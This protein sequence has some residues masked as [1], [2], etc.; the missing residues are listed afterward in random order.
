[1]KKIFDKQAESYFLAT[2]ALEG[3]WDI[4]KPIIF[5]G[6]W[7]LRYSRKSFWE[8]LEYQII[9]SPL[10]SNQEFYNAYCYVSNLYER[11]LPLLGEKL[12][13][14]HGTS[15]SNRYWRIVIGPW[16]FQYIHVLYDRY[17]SLRVALD[18]YSNFTTIGLSEDDYI[19]PSN[20][21]DFTNLVCDD[22]YNLQL[23]TRIL[24]VLGKDFPRKNL[25]VI[26]SPVL[27]PGKRKLRKLLGSFY[28][29]IFKVVQNNS[30]PIVIKQAYFSRFIEL[31]LFFKT[32]GKIW[33]D[34]NK[35]ELP[36]FPFNQQM[37]LKLSDLQLKD[38]EFEKLLIDMLFFDIPKSY[39]E[40]FLFISNEIDRYYPHKPIAIFSAEAWY[41]EEVFKQWAAACAEKGT[42]LFGIQHG[43]NYGSVACLPCEIHEVSITDV[44]YSWGWEKTD[45][46]SRVLP[47]PATRLMG[48]KVMGANNQKEGI[49]LATNCMP[50]YLYRFQNFKNYDNDEYFSWQQRFAAALSSENRSKMR[51]RLYIQDYGSDCIQRW[52]DYYPEVPLENWDIYFLE[53]LENCRLHVSDHL[54]STFIDALVANK[55]TI[56]FWNH[57]VFEVRPEAQPYYDELRYAG[58]L[59]NTPEAAATAVNFFYTDVETWWN[60]PNLQVIRK[61]F[62]NIFAKTSPDAVNEWAN[63]FKT[64][65]REMKIN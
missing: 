25:K 36:L 16:L 61:K 63:K 49:L 28:N 12:N 41:F 1:M 8:N 15:H 19:T 34:R 31:Q 20:A 48:R 60:D 22:P 64:I 40:G 7:C 18:Q 26:T 50:R 24:S 59:Y 9:Q 5:L 2:T 65:A 47:L 43:A 10:K 23:Y 46:V 56:L 11:I 37:R 13:F 27:N 39:I 33:Q 32:G 30:C 38:C 58:I 4:S 45:L 62:C 44:F 17:T 3:F 21:L 54:A 14:I 52:K 55:P 35:I 53:S 51:V 42:V 29:T 6:G 57:Q